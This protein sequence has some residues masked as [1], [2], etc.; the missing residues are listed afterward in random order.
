LI[1]N[2]VVLDYE[3]ISYIK[4]LDVNKKLEIIEKI[5]EIYDYFLKKVSFS[6]KLKTIDVWYFFLLN[7]LEPK[8][9][10]KGNN[11][12]YTSE[13]YLKIYLN[14][15]NLAIN[16]GHNFQ[17]IIDKLID[18]LNIWGRKGFINDFKI[19]NKKFIHYFIS[20]K[21]NIIIYLVEP[22]SLKFIINNI[23]NLG[24]EF[25]IG[26]D[27]YIFRERKLV[28]SFSFDQVVAYEIANHLVKNEIKSVD[29]NLLLDLYKK[30]R[31]EVIR[32]VLS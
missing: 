20:G 9:V 22:S 26:I 1:Y 4:G 32:K 23:Q 5:I 21:D 18:Y 28:A 14:I 11:S 10:S 12:F 17:E 7:K 30:Y 29:L 25:R 15:K 6:F 8:P 2:L 3:F 19:F 24:I 16:N 13:V 27:K 31:D